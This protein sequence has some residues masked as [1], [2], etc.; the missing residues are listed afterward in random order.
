MFSI[1]HDDKYDEESVD[2]RFGVARGVKGG[3]S[4]SKVAFSSDGLDDGS[5]SS[6]VAFSMDAYAVD[7][8]DGVVCGGGGREVSFRICFHKYKTWLLYLWYVA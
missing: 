4:A 6:N 8:E 3:L 5:S 2:G 1:P 7:G